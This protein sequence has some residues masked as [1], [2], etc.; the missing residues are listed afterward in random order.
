MNDEWEDKTVGGF[1]VRILCT[2][3]KGY[4]P[5]VGLISFSD[6]R[7]SLYMFSKEGKNKSASEIL[8]LVRKKKIHGFWITISYPKN[9]CCPIKDYFN[10]EE[11]ALDYM[12]ALERKLVAI[13]YFEIEEG[14][15][16]NG[17]EHE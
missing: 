7:E 12:R 6:G 4:W 9:E 3:M 1:P 14:E 10:T 8:D 5:I 11:E 17:E 13:Q 15:G 2:D 16:M